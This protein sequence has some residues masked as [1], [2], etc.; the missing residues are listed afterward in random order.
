[1]FEYTPKQLDKIPSQ[2]EKDDYSRWTSV[3]FSKNIV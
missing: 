3:I 2:Q 1:M